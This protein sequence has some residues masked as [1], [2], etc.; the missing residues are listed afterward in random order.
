MCTGCHL[1]SWG[2]V[3]KLRRLQKLLPVMAATIAQV[4]RFQRL[5]LRKERLSY[6]LY[7]WFIP[8]VLSFVR[9]FVRP[10]V[11]PAW[12]TGI[13]VSF[14]FASKLRIFIWPWPLSLHSHCFLDQTRWW[15]SCVSHIV[16]QS[17]ALTR[18]RDHV[19]TAT[20]SNIHLDFPENTELVWQ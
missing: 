8:F 19:T 20:S 2:S 13:K 17:D 11:R 1:Y 6:F 12:E 14:I 7:P 4:N 9:S 10:S 18:W 16:M 3:V 5:I 15:Q